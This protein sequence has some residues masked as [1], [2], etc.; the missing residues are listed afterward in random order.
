M[1][2]AV[3]LFVVNKEIVHPH[4]SKRLYI[5]G[6]REP[7]D[8]QSQY[9]G[10]VRERPRVSVNRWQV[11][12]YRI[13]HTANSVSEILYRSALSCGVECDCSR[14]ELCSNLT[15]RLLFFYQGLHGV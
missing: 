10:F 3:A 1:A 15:W 2:V 5:S 8:C 11:P 7:A 14:F 9:D 6:V 12:I 4:V 13:Q